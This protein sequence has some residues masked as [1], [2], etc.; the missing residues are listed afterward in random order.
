MLVYSVL[1]FKNLLYFSKDIFI[2]KRT[3][4]LKIISINSH[5]DSFSSKGNIITLG[6]CTSVASVWLTRSSHSDL[7]PPLCTAYHFIFF[8]YLRVRASTCL[9][10][11]AYLLCFSWSGS[12]LP[13]LPKL[14]CSSYSDL[15]QVP[16]TPCFL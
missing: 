12:P 8:S 15:F 13:W 14:S 1:E 4:K 5:Q 7:L 11:H 6:P 3:W 2:T 16:L 9:C 10:F